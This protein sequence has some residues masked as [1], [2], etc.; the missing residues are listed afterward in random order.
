MVSMFEPVHGS[1]PPL[2]RKDVANPMAAILSLGMMLR[3][4]GAAEAALMIERAIRAA[5]VEDVV[6][7]D[8]GGQHGTRA[9]GD[10]IA[11]WIR[12]A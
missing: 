6:T 5:I 9:V 3:T 7:R 12:R 11:E 1:A 2:A 8:L 4:V 10:W